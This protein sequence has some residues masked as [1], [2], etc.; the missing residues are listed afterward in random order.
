MHFGAAENQQS[1]L[2]A[3][4]AGVKRHVRPDVPHEENQNQRAYQSDYEERGVRLVVGHGDGR[5]ERVRA[6]L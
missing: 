6:N 3:N 2:F 1:G 5:R 4:D